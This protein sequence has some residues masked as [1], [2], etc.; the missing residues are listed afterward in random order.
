MLATAN[1]K[2]LPITMLANDKAC[3]KQTSW[4]VGRLSNF[5]PQIAL[6][7][8]KRLHWNVLASAS[9]KPAFME[10]LVKELVTLKPDLLAFLA[11]EMTLR[12]ERRS[13]KMFCQLAEEH[14]KCCKGV[15]MLFQ[16]LPAALPTFGNWNTMT[17]NQQF[18]L[19]NEHCSSSDVAHFVPESCTVLAASEKRKHKLTKNQ[20]MIWAI[21]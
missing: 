4:L 3:S 1:E 8:Q 11:T 16:C 15:I 9:A 14:D 6:V 18:V 17:L 5:S 10:S 12:N 2:S 13:Y 21:T 20:W 7:V 19:T